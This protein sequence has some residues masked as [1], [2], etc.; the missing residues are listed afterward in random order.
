MPRAQ[1]LARWLATFAPAPMN[2]SWRER[3][4]GCVGAGL[5]ILCAA[6]LSHR[7]LAGFSP[8]FIAPMGASAVLV[9]AAPASPLAQP[10]SLVC[11]NL[12]SALVGVAC[13]LGVGNLAIAAMFALRCLHPPGG[14]VALTAVLGG[15]AIRALGFGFVLWPVAIDSLLLLLAALLFNVSAR[16]RYP[17]VAQGPA[18]PVHAA[19]PGLTV[20]D[21]HAALRAHGEL[22]DVS[23]DDLGELFL[24]AED[25]ARQRASS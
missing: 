5:G 18:L 25:I 8:W 12:V 11:G 9:F 3:V 4:L 24:Q 20:A 16:R 21:L 13:A 1:H 10:W 17:H 7:L 23:E 2:V 14:A 15:P 22:L 6:W 19:P